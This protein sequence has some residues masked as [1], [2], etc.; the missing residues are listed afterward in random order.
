MKLFYWY[1]HADELLR[2]ELEK[3]LAML[4]RQGVIEAWHDRRILAGD[5]ID[6]RI[7]TELEEAG[8]ILLLVSSDF[9]ASNY[10]YD[11]EM[12]RALERH[13]AG[14]A[15]VIPVILR[16]CDWQH[17]PFGRRLATPRDGKPVV[18]WPSQDEGFLDVVRSIRAAATAMAS[19]V[20]GSTTMRATGAT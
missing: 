8:I 14:E 9:L 16:P 19:T 7:S 2:D 4:R 13:A 18:K 3:H 11:R 10:C 6:Q 20:T 12:S 1:S 5:P 15:R 17:A